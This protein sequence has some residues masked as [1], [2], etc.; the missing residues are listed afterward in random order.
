VKGRAI[1]HKKAAK[2]AS[3]IV[4]GC[5]IFAWNELLGDIT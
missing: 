2:L 1:P 5:V 4:T 3:T